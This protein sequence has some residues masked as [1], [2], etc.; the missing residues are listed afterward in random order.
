MPHEL[1]DALELQRSWQA[2]NTACE[3]YTRRAGVSSA[4]MQ[5]VAYL[6]RE[7]DKTQKEMCERTHLPKQTVNK[8]ITTLYKRGFVEMQELQKDLRAKAVRLTPMG[9][10]H[11]RRMV[12]SLTELERKALASFTPEQRRD[13]V[14][15]LKAVTATV[16]AS[17]PPADAL[18]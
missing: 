16:E 18:A 4:M 15:M 13:F 6:Y 12:E 3:N 9:R 8:V 2:F 1:N 14:A 17:E 11:A 7:P 5:V 10:R